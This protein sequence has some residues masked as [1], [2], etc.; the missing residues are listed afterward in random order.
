[1]LK[2]IFTEDYLLL[3]IIFVLGFFITAHSIGFRIFLEPKLSQIE[4][5]VFEN[6]SSYV[7]GKISFL[8]KLRAEYYLSSKESRVAV[9]ELIL[10]ESASIQN[11]NLPLSMK[12]FIKEL[13]K[14]K[15]E[16]KF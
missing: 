7:Q 15:D 4:R 11:E 10:I 9:R 1:M 2:K 3:K 12:N 16:E 8:N 6:S 13:Q 5:E 14:E